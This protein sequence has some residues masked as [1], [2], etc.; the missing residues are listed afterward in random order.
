MG[1][2]VYACV[3]RALT[4]YYASSSVM[5]QSVYLRFLDCLIL[6]RYDSFQRGVGVGGGGTTIEKG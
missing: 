1:F 2:C 3:W 6:Y 4:F 5:D